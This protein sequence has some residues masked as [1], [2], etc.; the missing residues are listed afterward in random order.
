MR[1]LALVARDIPYIRD[2]WADAVHHVLADDVTLVNVSAWLACAPKESHMK[3]I[4]RLLA[5][6]TYDYLFLYHDYIFGDFPDEFFG[7]VRSAGIKTLAYHP[8]DEPE[9]WYQRNRVYD[10]RFD[11]VASHCKRGVERRTAEARPTQPMYLPWGF[12]QRFFDRAKTRVKPTYDVVFCGK[13]KVHDQDPNA[14]REDGEQR[15]LTLNRVAK[16][17]KR[18]GWKFGLFGWGWDKHPTLS[19][20]AGGL[21]TQEQMVRTYHSARIVLNPGWTSDPGNPVA[22]TKLR[23]FEVPGAGAFQLTNANPE[24]DELLRE[25]KEVA[26]FTDNDDLCD[27]IAYYLK[28]EKKRQAIADCGYAR[29]H[30]EHTLDHRVRTLFAEAERRWPARKSIA[31]AR[32]MPRIQTIH[33]RSV[34]EVRDLRDRLA[35]DP[36]EIANA[37]AVHVLACNGEIGATHYGALRDWWRAD[38]PVFAGRTFYSIPDVARNPVHPRRSEITGD[39]LSER[40]NLEALPQWKRQGLLREAPAVATDQHARFLMNYVARREAVLPL[41]D[42]FLSG[43]LSAVEAL[44]PLDTGLVLAEVYIRLTLPDGET[45]VPPF[46]R[47]LEA[48]L[49]QAAALCQRV[50][51]YGARGDMAEAA[52]DVVRKVDRINLVGLFDRAMA[53]QRVAGVPV[54]S[55]FDIPE[56]AP[57]VLLIAAAHSGPAIYEQLKPLESRMALVPLYDV[58]APTWNVLVSQ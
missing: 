26:F 49:R 8:D 3:N 6:G 20:Y 21:L 58:N 1:T 22:Q 45:P 12:N 31:V 56:V 17:C 52:F 9:T 15:D 11:L 47:P 36:S 29:A 5:T 28:N 43:H 27:K 25:G 7:N 33:L 24:L 44:K 34:D 35:V 16:L 37:E 40:V 14:Y 50:A 2:N 13:Y 42:A 53:G 23:H 19:A 4:Y 48:L 18:R 32:P 10:G 57:D 51:I 41:L 39:F 55:S 38:V 54:Y 46:V 30:R